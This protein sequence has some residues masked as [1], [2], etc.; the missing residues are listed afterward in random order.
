M[1]LKEIAII[2][3]TAIQ[4][5]KDQCGWFVSLYG[6]AVKRGAML[7]SVCGNA[8]TITAAKKDYAK[9]LCSQTII[10]TGVPGMSR[11][12]FKLPPKITAR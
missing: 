9:K 3:G 1:T 6:V 11:Q 10:V 2:T 12:E 5:S 4:K 7:H 8:K